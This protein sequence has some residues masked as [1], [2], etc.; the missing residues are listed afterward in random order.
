MISENMIYDKLFSFSRELPTWERIY[1]WVIIV[2]GLCGGA[3][4]TYKALKNIVI[5]DF[6][7]P[8]Y[9]QSVNITILE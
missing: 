3:L 1:C 8:C 4:A 7:M 5:T 9:L 2:I 6:A